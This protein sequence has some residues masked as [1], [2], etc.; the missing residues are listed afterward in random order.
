MQAGLNPNAG[1]VLDTSGSGW[2][3]SNKNA[4][5]Q[6]QEE[7]HNE[8]FFHREANADEGAG[9]TSQPNEEGWYRNGPQQQNTASGQAQNSGYNSRYSYDPNQNQQS[10]PQGN[11]YAAYQQAG[12]PKASE[13]YKWNYEDYQK[14]QPKQPAKQ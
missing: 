8:A 13:S 1:E 9:Q 3:F 5:N 6:Q 11:P 4:E 12:D 2:V 7:P 14:G 10:A